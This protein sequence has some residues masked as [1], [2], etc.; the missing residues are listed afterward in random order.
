[1]RN[2]GTKLC[3]FMIAGVLL[4]ASGSAQAQFNAFKD[5]VP[6]GTAGA[7][8]GPDLR[9]SIPVITG[10]QITV[11]ATAYVVA[12]FKNG[13][14]AP[15]NVKGINLYPSSTV[16]ATVSLNKCAEAPLPPEAECAVTVAVTGLQAGAWR[17]EILL[18]HD[19][20]TRL[21][22]A[23]MTGDVAGS[24]S[25]VDDRIRPDIE[26]TPANLDFASVSGAGTAL[27]KSVIFRNRTSD[28][29]DIKSIRLDAP[30]QSG[31][32]YKSECQASLKPGEICNVIVTW[33]PQNPGIA[34]GVLLMQHSANSS[35]TQVEINGTY[36]PEAV[37]NA[38]IYPGTVPERGLLVADRDEIDF[39]SGI[40][41]AS[42]ITI[43]LVNIGSA[44][45]ALKSVK[46][47]GSDSGLSVARA[48]CT[49]GTVLKPV[50]ACALTLNWVPS[51]EGNIV[52]DLQV[53]HTG[54]RGILI[55][56][57][58][59]DADGAVSRE[60][61][62]I[63]QPSLLEGVSGKSTT[64]A[65]GGTAIDTEE[66]VSVTPVLDGYK[67]TS[68]SQ[69]R[70]VINGPVGSLVV[71]DGE[72]VV[73]SG[74]KWTVS[75]VSTGV[76]LTSAADEILLVFDKSL[77]PANPS[78]AVQGESGTSTDSDDDDDQSASDSSNTSPVN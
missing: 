1:M 36:T 65:E 41:G 35:I 68:H 30:E 66:I 74:V 12:L 37:D 69:Q 24:V 49:P 29:V 17:V 39:G 78:G 53:H 16:T 11:G 40:N 59:G 23:A 52:D 19:G 70:A 8:S 67:I 72:D 13:G 51:R 28:P 48:G 26:A 62:A 4:C 14:T 46:L 9:A 47:S 6:G 31:F 42:A 55:I 10:G 38:E 61:L 22:T 20:R 21:A 50:D 73:V 34:Q 57:V 18:D 32:A 2:L 58:R 3:S 63:R 43:S 64:D 76:I 56:P 5:P 27:V 15:V 25:D 7:A 44:D 75:I 71:R 33:V 77:K 45:V 60:S 54:A